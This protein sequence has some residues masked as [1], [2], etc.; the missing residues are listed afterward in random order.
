MSVSWSWFNGH[1]LW[2]VSR[3]DMHMNVNV[4]QTWGPYAL[5]NFLPTFMMTSSNGNIFRVTGHVCGEFTAPPVNSPHK[6]QWRGA[7]M[8]SLICVWI[9]GWVNKREA[10]DLRRYRTHYDVIVM[11]Y[12]C[13]WSWDSP[14]DHVIDN[15]GCIQVKSDISYC[16]YCKTSW[17]IWRHQ[18]ETFSALLAI[19]AGNSPAP[20]EFPA[21]RPVTRSFDVFFDLRLN[22]RLSKQAWGWWFETLS[23]PLWRHCNVLYMHLIIR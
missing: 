21:Q 16:S 17:K 1:I 22:T 7:L 18:M 15:T 20:G 4:K 2:Y 8:F 3:N 13:I 23:H 11:C 19:C 5:L 12:I 6:G 10:G 14:C 9:H